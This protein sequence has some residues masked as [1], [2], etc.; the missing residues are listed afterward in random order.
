MNLRSSS[1]YIT[2]VKGACVLTTSYETTDVCHIG[3]QESAMLVGD[4]TKSLV[5]P[6]ARVRRGT[7]YDETRL[8]DLRLRGNTFVVDV[9]CGGI[10]TVWE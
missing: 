2:V 10:K 9:L 7:T 8:V 4:I 3:H 5:V 6:I 1:D